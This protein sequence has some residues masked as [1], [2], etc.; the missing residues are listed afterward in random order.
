MKTIKAL[1]ILITCLILSLSCENKTS[2]SKIT[3]DIILPAPPIKIGYLTFDTINFTDSKGLKQGIWLTT[4]D[5]IAY[6]N[7]T[8][9]KVTTSNL[10][11]I[12]KVLKKG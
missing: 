3:E 9:Y 5:T 10:S 8:A 2:E 4:K 11:E 6:K 1:T 12:F 7:D